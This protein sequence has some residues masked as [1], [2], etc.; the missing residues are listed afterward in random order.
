[1]GNNKSTFNLSKVNTKDTNN[2]SFLDR[3]LLYKKK[4]DIP[5]S[6]SPDVLLEFIKDNLNLTGD[7]EDVTYLQL[8]SLIENSQLEPNKQYRITDYRPSNFLNG[9]EIANNNPTPNVPSFNPIQVYQGAID[10]LIVTAI[11]ENELSPIARSENYPEDI[12]WYYP[13]KRFE[14]RILNVFNGA[15]MPDSSVASGIDLQWNGS[16]VYVDLPNGFPAYEGDVF[17]YQCAFSGGLQYQ[18]AV[19]MFLENNRYSDYNYSADEPPYINNGY[20]YS[21]IQLAN[22]GQRIIFT[23][24]TYNDYLNY[25]NSSLILNIPYAIQPC[26]GKVL[27]R[28]DTKRNIDVCWD[29]RDCVF[30]RYEQDLSLAYSYLPSGSY[31]YTG[32]GDNYLGIGTTGNY[33]DKQSLD[34]RLF[35]VNNLKIS[36]N[37]LSYYLNNN[38]FECASIKDLEIN[39]DCYNNYFITPD[40]EFNFNSYFN[41]VQ[42]NFIFSDGGSIQNSINRL[43]ENICFFYSFENNQ[44]SNFEGNRLFLNYFS[45]NKINNLAYNNIYFSSL[46]SFTSSEFRNND[47]NYF[48]NN[49]IISNGVTASTIQNNSINTVY[50]NTWNLSTLFILSFENNKGSVLDSNTLN[51]VSLFSFNN[52]KYFSG[53]ILNNGVFNLNTIEN[54]FTYNNINSSMSNNVFFDTTSSNFIDGTINNCRFFGSFTYNQNTSDLFNNNFNFSVINCLFNNTGLTFQNNVILIPIN[55]RNYNSSTHVYQQYTC[56]I[57]SRQGAMLPSSI[58]LRYFDSSDNM[59]I[60]NDN[61]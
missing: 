25:D 47:F 58:R 51:N 38:I 10:P 59:I 9:Q 23:D 46:F 2:I 35:T 30:R 41:E 54:Y 18:Q 5:Y 16:E 50:N 32:I 26:T 48:N 19:W 6:L 55:G 7:I 61:A 42:N 43:I 37:I 34:W 8:L 39:G 31:L 21:R 24:L 27:R 28:I 29:W 60:T 44:I 17:A 36:F 15:V 3:F 1:M 11:S 53:N 40:D 12:I 45:N 20:G 49:T 33:V 14:S 57:F 22:N 4:E 13:L 56:E 52:F